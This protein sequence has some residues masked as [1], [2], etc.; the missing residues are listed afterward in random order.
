MSVYQAFYIDGQWVEPTAKQVLGDALFEVVNPADETVLT[1]VKSATHQEVDRAVR[2]ARI[3][4]DRWSQTDAAKRIALLERLLELYQDNIEKMGHLISKE[5]GAPIDFAIE[6]QA[7]CGAGHI[8]TTIDVLKQYVFEQKLGPT[9]IMKE[10]VGVCA[11]ITPWNWPMNQ[12]TCKVAPALGAG[13]TM[14]LKPSEQTPL[15]AHLFAQLV[16]QAGFPP[17]VFNLLQGTGERVGAYL[18]EHPDVDMVSFTGST[19][20][21][22]AVSKAAADT[23]KRVAL[24]LGGKSPS[25]VF[26]DADLEAAVSG[27]VAHCMDNSGQSCNAPTRLLV[28]ETIYEQA[29][30]IAERE[31]RETAVKSPDQHGTFI[32]PLVNA[33]QY[34]H[35]QT[36]INRGLSEG[37]KL[38]AG[39][40]GRPDGM[41]QGYYCRP[42]VFADVTNEMDVARTEIFGPVVCLIKFSTEQ[43]AV[44]IANDT[45]YGLAAYVHTQDLIKA[46][47]VARQLRAG[48]VRINGAAHPYTAPFGGYKRSGT[49][50]EWGLYGLEEYLETK[51]ISA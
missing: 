14:V 50:R 23:I 13:A 51:A 22:A 7:A 40:P 41:D 38:I 26:D 34:D 33:K 9:Q 20:A 24:E 32:G 49:G 28:H 4:F 31:A 8:Q 45:P 15:S 42:T 47:R 37:A 17:G 1:Q 16:D 35:V 25:I 44:A 21:G 30:V 46:E 18:S 48:M 2:V 36:L 29:L 19:R 10:P 12:I 5:M 43:E 6:S 3:A 27:T 39:G 11:L